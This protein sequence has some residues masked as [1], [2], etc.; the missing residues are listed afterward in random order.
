MFWEKIS[1]LQMT[2]K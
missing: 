2:L 1:I